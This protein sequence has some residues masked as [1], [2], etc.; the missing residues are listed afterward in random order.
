MLGQII[1]AILVY[2]GVITLTEVA[3]RHRYYDLARA[4]CN[5]IG[6]PLLRVGIKRSIFEPPNGDVTLDIDLAVLDIPGGVHGDERDMPFADKQFGVCFNEHT[7]EHLRTVEDV[8]LA[9][10][11]CTRVADYAIF[12]CPSPYS[13]YATLFCPTH[14]LRLK[15]EGNTML[16]TDNTYNTGFSRK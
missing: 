11:E 14:H 7:L 12:L 2:E 9:V 1:A 6:K 10:A 16:V 13:I 4:Y 15:F 3:E 8:E 5:A